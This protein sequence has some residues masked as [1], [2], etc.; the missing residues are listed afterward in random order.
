MY[1]R[2]IEAL[3]LNHC[4]RGSELSVTYSEGMFVALLSSIQSACA[5]LY[6]IWGL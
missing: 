4:F 5:V 1:K 6:G 2:K 3:S